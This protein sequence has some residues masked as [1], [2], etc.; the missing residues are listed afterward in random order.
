[1]ELGG[2]QLKFWSN[3]WAKEWSFYMK[4]LEHNNCRMPRYFGVCVCVLGVGGGGGGG[5]CVC[6]CVGGCLGLSMDVC[7]CVSV[8]VCGWVCFKPFI[9][10]QTQ[11]K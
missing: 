10:H 9:W 7:A 8:C 6:A 4:V 2:K 1:M 11:N 3:T 5:G